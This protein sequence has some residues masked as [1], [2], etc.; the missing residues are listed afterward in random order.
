MNVVMRKVSRLGPSWA[1]ANQQQQYHHLVKKAA[2]S[3][4]TAQQ[5]QQQHHRAQSDGAS[6]LR[7]A[8]PP[9]RAVW[10]VPAAAAIAGDVHRAARGVAQ[11]SHHQASQFVLPQAATAASKSD[12]VQHVRQQQVGPAPPGDL[13][14]VEF[15]E[16]VKME[17]WEFNDMPLRKRFR[18]QSLLRYI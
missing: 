5:H 14:L 12:V 1:G 9:P 7:V 6:R 17:L 2:F 18:V 16:Q 3:A 10:K 4:V 8:V 13:R 15:M 11:A